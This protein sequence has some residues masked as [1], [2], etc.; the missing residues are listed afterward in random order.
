M[1][2]PEKAHSGLGLLEG[3]EIPKLMDAA[4]YPSAKPRS[5]PR[6]AARANRA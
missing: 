6:F 3:G 5:N 4:S 1:N 2:L